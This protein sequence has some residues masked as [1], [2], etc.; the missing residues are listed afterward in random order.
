MKMN[1]LSWIIYIPLQILFLPAVILR[2]SLVGYKQLVVSKTRSFNDCDR[3]NKR[4]MDHEYI[5]YA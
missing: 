5:R 3:S 1:I 2:V 4:S